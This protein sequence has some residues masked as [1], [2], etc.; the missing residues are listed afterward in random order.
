LGLPKESGTGLAPIGWSKPVL[1]KITMTRSD[2]K[3]FLVWADVLLRPFSG[4]SYASVLAAIIHGWIADDKAFGELCDVMGI[5][6]E[7]GS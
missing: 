4:A 1:D 3:S 5:P 2:V 6:L 7:S